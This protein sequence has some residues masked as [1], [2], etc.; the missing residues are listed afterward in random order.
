MIFLE[1]NMTY[2][3]LKSRIYLKKVLIL[4][5]NT[6]VQTTGFVNSFQH[7]SPIIF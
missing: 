1:T 5:N 2:F 4:A 6:L 3:W 7:I